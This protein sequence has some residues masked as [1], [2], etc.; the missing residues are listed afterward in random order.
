M[1]IQKIKQPLNIGCHLRTVARKVSD[2]WPS[3]QIAM[4]TAMTTK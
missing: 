1:A 4:T 3:S 2:P